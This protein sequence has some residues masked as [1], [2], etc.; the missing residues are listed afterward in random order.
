MPEE[1]TITHSDLV[2]D[3]SASGAYGARQPHVLLRFGHNADDTDWDTLCIT[4]ADNRRPLI[5]HPEFDN[6]MNDELEEENA[7][8]V[9]VVDIAGKGLGLRTV[10]DISRGHTFVTERPR[11]SCMGTTNADLRDDF[12]SLI[13]DG[14]TKEHR[15]AYYALHNCKP[16]GPGTGDSL[17]IMRTNG[18]AA[19]WPF[20]DDKQIV[21]YD[22]IARA[23]HSCIPN[24]TYDWDLTFAGSLRSLAPIKKGEEITIT[25]TTKMFRPAEERKAELLQKYAFECTCPACSLPPQEQKKSDDRRVAISERHGLTHDS[26]FFSL[27]RIEHG[28]DDSYIMKTLDL[29]DVEGLVEERVDMMIAYAEFEG[30]RARLTGEYS[31][32]KKLAKW[33]MDEINKIGYVQK[34][35]RMEKILEQKQEGE[36][37]S[38]QPNIIELLGSISLEQLQQA[39]QQYLTDTASTD[40]DQKRPSQE[41]VNVTQEQ[42]EIARKKTLQLLLNMLMADDEVNLP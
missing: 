9:E 33:S 13:Q 17:G 32:T 21:V 36:N 14:M 16:Q 23:N 8:S 6:C 7:L 2:A 15:E 42:Q 35:P 18:L 25:Y 28:F 38:M 19:E 37:T 30:M 11:L 31:R 34:L 26:R 12:D 5:N 40:R 4:N 3:S 29:C 39:E 24:A 22:L 27:D 20:D 1:T 10:R 41:V